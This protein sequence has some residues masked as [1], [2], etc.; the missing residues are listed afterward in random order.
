MEFTGSIQ[1]ADESSWLTLTTESD[2]TVTISVMVSVNAFTPMQEVSSFET[3]PNSGIVRLPA[4]E[5]LR[6]LTG[7]GIGMVKGL[8]AATQG[9]SSCSYSFYVLPCRKFAYKS[10]AATIFTTRPTK[11]PVYEGAEDRLYFYRTSGEVS[12]Y[13]R[14]NYLAGGPS[15]SYK[16]NPT[17]YSPLRYYDLDISADTMLATASAKGLN[18]SNI[19][20]YDVWIEYSGNK[21]TVYS[22]DI[23]RMRLPLKTYKFLG[24]RGTYEYIHATGKF[25]RSIESETQVIVTSGIEEELTN[26]STMTFEQNSGHIESA[27]MGAYWLEFLASKKRYIIEKDGSEKAIIVDEFKTSLTDREVSSLSFT[28][29]YANPNDT[30]IDNAEIA[31]TGLVISGASSVNN[32]SNEAQYE[33]KYSPS[34]TTQRGVGWSVAGASYAS[35]GQD[36]KLTVLKGASGN[37]VKVRATSKENTSIYAEKSVTVTYKAASVSVTG[38]KLSRSELSLSVGES[39]TLVATVMPERATDNS[40]VWSSSAP[41]IAS[42][43]QSGNV[44]ALSA[45]TAV[46]TATTN[47]GGYTASC[48]LSVAAVLK[49][50]TLTVNCTTSGATVRVLEYVAGQTSVKDA[51]DYTEPMTFKENTTVK[52]WCHKNGMIDSGTQTVLM[53]S[54][55]TVSVACKAY[56]SWDL[57][58]SA[59]EEASGGSLTPS[60]SDP[61]SVGWTLRSGASWITV[62]EDGTEFIIAENT[63][64]T[65][66]TGKVSLVIGAVDRLGGDEIASCKITQAATDGQ[67]LPSGYTA[68]DHIASKGVSGSFLGDLPYI[69]TGIS[70]RSDYTYHVEY[71]VYPNSESGVSLTTYPF[72]MGSAS[73]RNTGFQVVQIY[74]GNFPGGNSSYGTDG[75]EGD[76]SGAWSGDRFTVNNITLFGVLVPGERHTLE[77]NYDKKFVSVDG[78]ETA[79]KF[80]GAS[81]AVS[82]APVGTSYSCY[83]FAVNMA[84]SPVTGN[85]NDQRRGWQKLHRFWI[86]DN[87]GTLLC[88]MHPCVNEAGEYGLYDTVRGLFLTTANDKTFTGPDDDISGKT[89]AANASI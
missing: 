57:G 20:S 37:T 69:D 58:T 23:K 74:T 28:W 39:E 63:S 49:Y 50:Y 15:D 54:D 81:G 61:D 53:T 64:P 48:N 76:Q 7:N 77:W 87:S 46:I 75:I 83:L 21:S 72:I 70:D 11:S 14:F 82:S 85:G 26:D 35:I 51:I 30:V 16:L 43:D 4:G 78:D 8:F 40:V 2:D 25:S 27:G 31:L 44:T 9:T 36:G 73:A 59:S 18:V 38:V 33:V 68:L 42:V 45:G 66:R 71:T 52:V 19:A 34:N 79:G 86:K 5:I 47:D 32:E 41:S 60:V 55:K 10:L 24:R 67:L 22:F 12:T 89:A 1:F 65:P 6:T 62:S 29:H 17:Y 56:P 88:D 84:G 80:V 13:V 3:T